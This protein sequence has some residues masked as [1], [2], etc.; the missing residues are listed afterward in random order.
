MSAKKALGPVIWP[1]LLTLIGVLLLLDNFL[2]LS[3]FNVIAL[4]PLLL[5]VVGAVMLLRGDVIP[6]DSARTFG[7]TRGS[8]ESALLEVSAGDLDV[9]VRDLER[10]GRLIAGQ[11]TANSRP[12]LTTEDT[13]A[14]LRLFRSATT[15]F[16]F[17]D[18]QLGLAK[19]L[20]WQLLISTS[21]G[22]VDMDLSQLIVEGGV[23]ATGVG[24]VRLICPQETL[25]PLKLQSSLG[26]IQLITPMGYKA[27]ITIEG[28]RT[29]T[30]NIDD[31]RYTQAESNLYIARDADPDAPIVDVHIR[32][33]F[34]DVY[35]A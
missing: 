23:V 19:D 8:V 30:R 27:R 22:Q 24:D 7:I 3:T 32:G 34:G 4:W 21:F 10:E 31:R 33:T 14:H 5:V 20:P 29:F 18:W 17:A 35:L 12:T 2:F 26:N 25:A 15:W 16:N 9:T 13:H 1:I 28:P 6:D 11:Y